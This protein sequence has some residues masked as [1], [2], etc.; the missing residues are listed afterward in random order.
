MNDSPE[1]QMLSGNACKS[2]RSNMSG[3]T[4]NIGALVALGLAISSSLIVGSDVEAQEPGPDMVAS[5]PQRPRLQAVR[6]SQPPVLDGK[7]DDPVWGEALPTIE[8]TQKFPNEGLSPSEQ[9]VLRILYDEES[10]YVAFDCVQ[11]LTPVQSRLARRDRK[12]ETDRVELSIDDGKSTFEFSVNAAGVLSDGVRFNDTGYSSDW[13]GVWEGQAARS[14]GGWSSEMR[15]P[16]RLF[17][18]DPSQVQDWGLQARR[19]VALR[20]EIDEWAYIPRV[21]AGE[22]SRYGR[23][24]G[25]TELSRG[26]PLELR[27]FV[28]GWLSWQDMSESA[29]FGEPGLDG[30]AGLDLKWRITQSLA[31][32]VALNPDFAQVEADQ[33]VL[34]LTTFEA[35]FPEKRPF[36][37]EGMDVFQEPRMKRTQTTQ[38][39]FY[40]RRIGAVASTPAVRSDLS[41]VVT[42]TP[43]PSTIYGAA[44]LTGTLGGDLTGGF[45][46]A[47]TARND[48]VVQS[49]DGMEESRLA[50]P[51]TLF[52]VARLRLPVGRSAH[53][54]LTATAANRMEDERAYPLLS[55]AGAM[56]QRLCPGGDVVSA[57]QRCFHDSYVIGMDGS[58]RSPDGAY[59]VNGQ[60]YASA[61]DEGPARILPD[62]TIIESGDTGSGGRLYAA[63][64]GGR[65]LGAV[66]LEGASKRLDYNDLGFMR[67]QNELRFVPGVEYRNLNPVW[68]VHESRLR[69]YSS[70][71]QTTDGLNLWRGY[72]VGGDVRFKNFWSVF[73]EVYYFGDRFDDREVGDGTAL[74]RSALVGMDLGIKTDPRLPILGSISTETLFVF[75]GF[76]FNLNGELSFHVLPQ[77]ELQLLPQ[78]TYTFGEPRYVGST[79]QPGEYLFG[80][81][82]ARGV[83][84]T[85]RT[86][87]AFTNQLTLQLYA[88]LLLVAKHYSEFSSYQS[89]L[90]D[91]RPAI[92]LEDLSPA[93]QP[94]VSPDIE[95]TTLNTNAVLR[96][97]FQP[98]STLFLVYTRYQAPYLAIDGGAELN[99]QALDNGPAAN[100]LWLKASYWWN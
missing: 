27:P 70:I 24:V 99:F 49:P 53:L 82:A 50:E 81:L 7:L 58:W 47:V 14:E 1:A 87:Y 84:A 68:Y 71:R 90:G 100:T 8:F 45:V 46:S 35:F 83:G 15:I 86:S 48:A 67:R 43:Q 94:A 63:K 39:L 66:E 25:L 31:L 61:I 69:A 17:R 40:T 42:S 10:L 96:W 29:A 21:D 88:Q 80:E 30:S 37:L 18:F 6:I 60:V 51:L 28:A 93:P 97:E 74:E 23:L 11:R 65:W 72:Y 38:T 64:E 32:D 98:G 62:G 33:E 4:R 55:D 26:N 77:L 59:I 78:V 2:A 3:R 73:S 41:E 76:S 92:R 5:M 19:Y 91:S 13:D 12:V 16:F 20:Q 89:N 52:N 57:G 34:N 79:D 44:K 95:E 85:L 36:F 54:G 22:V 9:T 75:N 56:P